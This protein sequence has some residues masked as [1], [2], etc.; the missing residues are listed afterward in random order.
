MG[1]LI[2][3]EALMSQSSHE[4]LSTPIHMSPSEESAE[5]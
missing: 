2:F 1:P 4:K 5:C 3:Q